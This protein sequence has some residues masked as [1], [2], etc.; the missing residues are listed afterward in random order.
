MMASAASVRGA[1]GREGPVSGGEAAQAEVPDDDAPAGRPR[2]D[3]DN[4]E[5]HEAASRHTSP[6]QR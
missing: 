5:D 4:D 6:L 2:R 3:T 1:D